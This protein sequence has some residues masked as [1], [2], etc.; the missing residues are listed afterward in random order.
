MKPG[1][2]A[3]CGA[4]TQTLDVSMMPTDWVVTFAD[5]GSDNQLY[6]GSFTDAI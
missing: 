3:A 6:I 4:V 5:D 1:S 2:H